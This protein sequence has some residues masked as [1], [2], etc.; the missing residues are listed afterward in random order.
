MCHLILLTSW[1]QDACSARPDPSLSGRDAASDSAFLRDRIRSL[2]SELK[3]SNGRA[4]VW[5][6]KAELAMGSERFLMDE[7]G[8]LNSKLKRK[9]LLLAP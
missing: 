7:L 2:E 4:D 9:F 5:K 3:Q 1:F 8:K 6:K